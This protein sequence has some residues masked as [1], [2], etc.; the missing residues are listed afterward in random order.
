MTL[1]ETKY[2]GDPAIYY[3]HEDNLWYWAMECGYSAVDARNGYPTAD[4]AEKELIEFL[5]D[6]KGPEK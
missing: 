3:D 6:W 1:A 2:V 5:K 4:Q